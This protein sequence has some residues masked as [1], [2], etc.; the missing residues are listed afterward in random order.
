MLKIYEVYCIMNTKYDEERIRE[1][2]SK[3]FGE[4]VNQMSIISISFVGFNYLYYSLVNI[5]KNKAN[6]ILEQFE[7]R[8]NKC[9]DKKEVEET[10]TIIRNVNKYI[11]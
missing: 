2:W 8:K 10:E 4:F 6:E 3:E 7:K 9:K 5:D 11:K 1:I